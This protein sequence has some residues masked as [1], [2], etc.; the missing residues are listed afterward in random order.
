[1]RIVALLLLAGCVERWGVDIPRL[2]RHPDDR[3]G[4]LFYDA[5]REEYCRPRA[6]ELHGTRCLPGFTRIAPEALGYRDELC[7]ELIAWSDIARPGDVYV[8]TM[9]GG[10]VTGMFRVEMRHAVDP[11][12]MRRAA[13]YRAVAGRCAA[14][15]EELDHAYVDIGRSIHPEEFAAVEP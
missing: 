14:V 11:R 15:R 3:D 13:L 9:A 4:A 12:T 5:V 2:N 1:M 8:A 10:A 7:T 6:T